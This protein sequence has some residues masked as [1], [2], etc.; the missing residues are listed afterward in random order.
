MNLTSLVTVVITTDL[1]KSVRNLCVIDVFYIVFVFCFSCNA[2]SVGL[3]FYIIGLG[4]GNH[5]VV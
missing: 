1:P 3:G 4:E 5:N 2:H